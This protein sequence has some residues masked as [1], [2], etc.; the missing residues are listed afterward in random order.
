LEVAAIYSAAGHQQAIQVSEAVRQIKEYAIHHPLE[1]HADVFNPIGICTNSNKPKGV[2][3][4]VFAMSA[5]WRGLGHDST[6]SG[7]RV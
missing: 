6:P 1:R 7:D 3:T 2:I 4:A 5:A